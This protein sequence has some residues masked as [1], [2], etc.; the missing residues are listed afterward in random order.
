MIDKFIA[1]KKF[2]ICSMCSIR[3]MTAIAYYYQIMKKAEKQL[4]LTCY[5]QLVTICSAIL[6]IQINRTV[7]HP[8]STLFYP[9]STP[10]KKT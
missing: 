2:V 7:F 9:L 1:V 3:N 6:R 8:N 10:P 4:G 5:L